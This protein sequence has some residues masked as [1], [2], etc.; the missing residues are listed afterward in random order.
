MYYVLECYGPADQDRAA[1]GG[2]RNFE[3]NWRLARPLETVPP[4]PIVVELNPEFPGIMMPM[5]DK[6]ILLFSNPMVTSI[7]N[8]GVDNIEVFDALVIDP[9]SGQRYEDY[10][11]VNI[12]GAVAAADLPKSEYAA[13][14]GTAMVDTDFDSLAIDEAKAGGHLMFRLAEAVT[15]I[16]IHERVKSQLEQDGIPYLNFVPPADWMG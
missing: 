2:V 3:V 8:A 6:G 10:K 12:V 11:A 14:S 15:A 7:R 1:I 16:V 4:R 9:G 13:P 5:F